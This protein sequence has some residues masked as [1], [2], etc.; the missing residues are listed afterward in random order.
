VTV[1]CQQS[2]EKDSERLSS[3]YPSFFFFPSFELSRF[4][5]LE[6]EEDSSMTIGVE[7]LPLTFV[8]HA[9]AVAGA[10]TVLVWNLYYRGG[11]AWEATNKSL[12]FN[13][14]LSLMLSSFY[15]GSVDSFLGVFFCVCVFILVFRSFFCLSLSIRFVIIIRI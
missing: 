3:F 6:E 12:I 15:F 1:K 14:S 7:A 13:V 5:I 10:V 11:L 2:K 9:L 8:A 4:K